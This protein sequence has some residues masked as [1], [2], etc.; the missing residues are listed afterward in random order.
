[1]G[2]RKQVATVLSLSG[3]EGCCAVCVCMACGVVLLSFLLLWVD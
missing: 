1:M 3:S 2:R